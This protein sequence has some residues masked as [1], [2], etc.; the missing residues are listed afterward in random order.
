MKTLVLAW[1]EV[2]E[3]TIQNCYKKSGSTEVDGSALMSD[4]PFHAFKSLRQLSEMKENVND[5][6][7][8][9]VA[10]FDDAYLP[11]K[12]YTPRKKSFQMS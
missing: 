12:N 6:S 2:T 3:K 9:E 8:E 1:D 11:H 5:L 7:T 10:S 4:N